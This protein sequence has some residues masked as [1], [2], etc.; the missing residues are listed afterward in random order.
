MITISGEKMKNDDYIGIPLT[1]DAYP[2]LKD[3]HRVKC[4]SGHVFHDNGQKLYVRKVQRAFK[5]VLKEAK[6]ENFHFHDLRHSFASF[7]VQSGT[8]L[9]VVQKLLGHKDNRM[10]QRY[11]HLNVEALRDAISRNSRLN[12]TNLSRPEYFGQAESM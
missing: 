6:I 2:T 10:T 7:Q 3:L 9:Y 5:V 4:V 8:N 1:D 11:S 12:R